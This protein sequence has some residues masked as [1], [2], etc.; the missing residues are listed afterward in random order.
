MF[1][2]KNGVFVLSLWQKLSQCSPAV[3]TGKRLPLRRVF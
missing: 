3:D 1:D 2:A